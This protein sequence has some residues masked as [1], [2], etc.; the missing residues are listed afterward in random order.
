[1]ATVIKTVMAG[2]IATTALAVIGTSANAA[3][4]PKDLGVHP[5]LATTQEA[6]VLDASQAVHKAA[7]SDQDQKSFWEQEEDR[8]G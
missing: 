6:Q 8:G 4:S 3:F 7:W 2:L 1:M 5:T